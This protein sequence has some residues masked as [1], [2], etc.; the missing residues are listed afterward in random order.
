VRHDSAW[1]AGLL[2]GLAGGFADGSLPP[3]AVAQTID[4]DDAAAGYATTW[5][6]DAGGR[7]VFAFDP[8]EP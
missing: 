2:R 3:I 1:C 4:L 8:V 6:G 7:V 5:A